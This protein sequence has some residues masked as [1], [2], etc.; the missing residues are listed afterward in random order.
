[1]RLTRIAGPAGPVHAIEIEGAWVPC[2][3]PYLAFAEGRHPEPTGEP[4]TDA[5]PLAPCA[6]TVVVGIAQNGQDAPS[7]VQAWLKSPRTVVASGT[8][9]PLRRGVGRNDIEGEVAV[10]VG[11]PSDG[12]T[13]A[14]AHEYVL[15]VTAVNDVSNP[16]RASSDPRNFE[17]KGGIAYTPLG[18]WI[19]T[20]ADLDDVPLHVDIDGVA[21]ARTSSAELPASIA[22]CLAYVASWIELGPGDVIMTG[23]P[24]SAFAVE[25]GAHVEI[26]VAGIPL[27]TTCS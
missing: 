11:R 7:P 18:P 24:H 10:V 26:T 27:V 12:L 6:P 5:V 23:A 4:V 19:E 15:G 16:A 20:E 3:D 25:P 13:A 1:M 9:V 14:N 8:T 21:R 17:G 22:D 2:E